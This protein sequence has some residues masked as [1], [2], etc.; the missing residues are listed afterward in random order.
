MFQIYKYNSKSK[1]KKHTKD[2]ATDTRHHW[3]EQQKL[4]AD[5]TA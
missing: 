1:D 5:Q 3:K 2:S 4:C